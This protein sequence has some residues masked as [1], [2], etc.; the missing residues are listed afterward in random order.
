M[1]TTVLSALV[2]AAAVGTAQSQTIFDGTYFGL[3]LGYGFGDVSSF[4]ASTLSI[5]GAAASGVIGWNGSN[6]NVVYGVE[7]DLSL[8]DVNGSATCFNPT[9]TC[10]ASVRA[11]GSLRGRVGVAQNNVLF[12]ATAGA[13]VAS[14]ELK[15]IN[16]GGT[17]FPDTQ[18][19]TGWVAG[20]GVEGRAGASNWN[21]RAEYLHHDF[22]TK[23]YNTDVPY[24][25]GVTVDLVRFMMTRSF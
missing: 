19:P 6:G 7:A 8:G 1:K 13:A 12:Y 3:G 24:T 11:F 5:E 2:L 14:V 18:T 23:T 21:Y 4:A 17:E 16:S 20:L 22:G 9:W 25:S 15:T 10:D